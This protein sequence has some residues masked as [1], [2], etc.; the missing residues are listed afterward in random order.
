MRKIIL[1]LSLASAMPLAACANLNT[2]LT[3]QTPTQV[4]TLGGAIQT[5]TLVNQIADTWVKVAKPSKDQLLQTSAL[6]TAVRSEMHKLEDAQA[7][8]DSLV[9]T[10]FNQALAALQKYEAD[11]KM[12]AA[13][14]AAST[15]A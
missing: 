4:T 5:S 11:N 2:Q 8:G 15:S 7:R 12:S 1:A 6:S 13:I 9:F 3:Q 14:A 10:A